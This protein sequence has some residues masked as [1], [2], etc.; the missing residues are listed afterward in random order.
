MAARPWDR[1]ETL[2]NLKHF[3][4]ARVPD[5]SKDLNLW[6]KKG[7]LTAKR[8]FTK[9]RD[10]AFFMVFVRFLLGRGSFF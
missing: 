7:T 9:F 8:E 2:A 6:R 3:A 1:N 4:L 5:L 10:F